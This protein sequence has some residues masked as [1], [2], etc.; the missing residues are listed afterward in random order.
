MD[1]IEKMLRDDEHLRMLVRI[2]VNMY[3]V[4]VQDK[5]VGYDKQTKKPIEMDGR[6]VRINSDQM[7][8]ATKN[9]ALGLDWDDEKQEVIIFTGYVDQDKDGVRYDN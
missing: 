1:T 2:L 9:M 7:M 6:Q 5:L 4:D 3:G 8:Q